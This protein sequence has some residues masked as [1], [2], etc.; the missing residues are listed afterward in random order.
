MLNVRVPNEFGPLRAAIVHD[1]SNAIDVTIEDQVRLVPPDELA[2]HPEAGSSARGRLID[3]HARF[4]KLLADRGVTLLSPDTQPDAFCQ[5]FAR[6]PCFA[7][8]DTLFVAGMR[9]EWR[10]P[11][12]VGLRALRGRFAKVVDLSGGGATIEGGDVMV[13]DGG[14]R[15]L[16]GM[17]RHTNAAG[18]RKLSDALGADGVEVVRIPHDALHLDCCVAPLP[19]G[20]ALY[21]E[22]KLA[23]SVATLRKCFRRLT[24]LDPD[25]AARHL[26]A[27]VFWLD[28][29]RVVSG[30]AARKTNDL[31]RGRGYEVVELDFSDLVALWGSFR[32][33]VCP[34]ERG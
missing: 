11:E 3:Q 33:V 27:N 25:E 19:D 4:R 5:V 22:D 29:R 23:R 12:T 20:E 13:L 30:A 18:L 2:R 8:G 24:P 16:V 17:N 15:V 10:H 1:G 28:E 14:G 21:A 9:D 31:L 34:V 32:C 7:V 26:A 6:D